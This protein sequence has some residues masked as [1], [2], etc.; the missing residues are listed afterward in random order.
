MSQSPSSWRAD[1]DEIMKEVHFFQ[2]NPSRDE[3]MIN[4]V[5]LLR[6]RVPTSHAD[7]KRINQQV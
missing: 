6:W 1:N 7:R 3:G 5:P 2:L 4:G